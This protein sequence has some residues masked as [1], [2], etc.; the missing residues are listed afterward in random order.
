MKMGFSNHLKGLALFILLILIIATTTGCGE[1][2]VDDTVADGDSGN[3]VNAEPE[4]APKGDEKSSGKEFIVKVINSSDQPAAL[5][6]ESEIDIDWNEGNQYIDYEDFALEP[7]EEEGTKFSDQYNPDFIKS[8][9]TGSGF[10][11]TL[12]FVAGV[13]NDGDLFESP[14][15]QEK[16]EVS[17][18]WGDT[19]I[20]DFDGT[21]FVKR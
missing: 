3:I 15:I 5:M 19:I 2:V 1:K 16:I 9:D 14:Y 6:V 11:V 4:A 8:I 17:G 20:F 12:L 13:N 10:K 21:G 18:E 7:G